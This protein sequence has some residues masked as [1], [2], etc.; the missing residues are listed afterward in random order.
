ML[1]T[2]PRC[3]TRF[4]LDD[5]RVG[6]AGIKLRCTCSA[7]FRV[8]FASSGAPASVAAPEPPSFEAE[9]SALPQE[10]L[11]GFG[12]ALAQPPAPELS[13]AHLKAQRLA[14][15]IISDIALY[16]PSEVAEGIRNGTLEQLVADDLQEGRN[17][18]ARRVSEDVRQGTRYLEEAFEAM[19]RK[20]KQELNLS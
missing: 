5:S 4:N 15:L 16:N 18:Y 20:K 6:P 7:L 3:A 13:E 17:L 12:E 11:S 1:I 10:P 14:R 9:P 2:C 19:V 8:R